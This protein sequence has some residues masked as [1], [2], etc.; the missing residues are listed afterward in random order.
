V[1]D[2]GRGIAEADHGRVF[3]LFRRAGSQ[4]QPGEGI[5]LAHVRTLVRALD[6]RIDLHSTPGA[7]TTFSVRLPLRQAAGEAA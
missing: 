4:D 1:S 2:N 7:G 5:G 3:E 6:G